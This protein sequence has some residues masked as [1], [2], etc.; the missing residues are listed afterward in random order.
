MSNNYDTAVLMREMEGQPPNYR[1]KDTQILQ[2][3]A[4]STASNNQVN[5]V[6]NPGVNNFIDW[7]ALSTGFSWLNVTTVAVTRDAAGGAAFAATTGLPAYLWAPKIAGFMSYINSVTIIVN[8]ATVS[9]SSSS[10]PLYNFLRYMRSVSSDFHAKI[11]PLIGMS[12]LPFDQ[13]LDSWLD[14]SVALGGAPFV[15][16]VST[17]C[18]IRGVPKFARTTVVTKSTTGEFQLGASNQNSLYNESLLKRCQLVSNEDTAARLAL[19]ANNFNVSFTS[20]TAVNYTYNTYC[21]LPLC[22]IHDFFAKL[23]VCSGLEMKIT[24]NFNNVT[25]LKAVPDTTVPAVR[26]PG[27][28]PVGAGTVVY[29]GDLMPIQITECGVNQATITGVV[30][31]AAANTATLTGVSL[32]AFAGSAADSFNATYRSMNATTQAPELYL[33]E[34]IPYAQNVEAFA[35]NV[36]DIRYS[37]HA[38]YELPAVGS[39]ISWNIL[40]GAQGISRCSIFGYRAAGF[41]ATT[42][43]GKSDICSP[44][45]FFSSPIFALNNPVFNVANTN[46]NPIPITDNN[47]DYAQNWSGYGVMGGIS[48]SISSGLYTKAAYNRS[49]IYSADLS[50][51]TQANE[52]TSLVFKANNPNAAGF[53]DLLAVVETDWLIRIRSTKGQM[54]RVESNNAG[55]LAEILE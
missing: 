32:A 31:L 15:A 29:N 34:V 21:Y 42:L 20:A 48:S 3:T 43:T 35:S 44:A 41:N 49:K 40:S 53:I 7:S 28:V 26:F 45:P 2:V 10:L 22:F 12:G 1:F 54:A 36:K 38:V 39:S 23:G 25:S 18:A 55:P 30:G 46:V 33:Q 13:E 14:S 8:G 9:S 37:D 24:F 4:Q 47:R 17:G 19:N 6:V 11:G 51:Y 52:Q 5:L 50:H 27:G 16:N